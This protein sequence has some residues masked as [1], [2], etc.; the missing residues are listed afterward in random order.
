MENVSVSLQ[1]GVFIW[2]F[3]MLLMAM[4]V[5]AANRK[6]WIDRMK[7]KCDEFQKQ[8][9][10]LVKALDEDKEAFEKEKKDLAEHY[11]YMER[12]NIALK[13][14]MR[15]YPDTIRWYQNILSWYTKIDGKK[16]NDFINE[17]VRRFHWAD[18]PSD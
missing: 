2:G 5:C 13:A 10:D 16:I 12:E 6:L 7:E 14:K 9:D 3:A 8:Y 15:N 18:Q 1:V 17:E 11:D 4:V